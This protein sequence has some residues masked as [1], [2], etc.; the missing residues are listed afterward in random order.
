MTLVDLDSRILELAKDHPEFRKI[1]A[2]A[3]LRSNIRIIAADAFA[4]VRRTDYRFDVIVADFPDPHAPALARLYSHEF[5]VPVKQRLKPGGVFVTQ[6]SS[7]YF[8]RKAFWA[9]RRTLESAG[10]ETSSFH[11][12]VPAFGDWG[13]HLAA[14]RKIDPKKLHVDVPTRYLA[15]DLLSSMFVFGKDV[16]RVPTDVNTLNNMKLYA[17]YRLGD[18]ENY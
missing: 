9:V 11:T 10:F 13:F 1:N 16:S 14:E 12:D 5:Y 18:W 15:N 4:W 7:P 8:A 2:D 6:S 3:L 17:Y